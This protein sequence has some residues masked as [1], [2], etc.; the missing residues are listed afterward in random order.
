M[1]VQEAIKILSKDTSFEAVEELKYYAGFNQDKV[2][3]QIQEAMTMGAKALEKQI[4]LERIVERLEE[5]KQS[6]IVNAKFYQN[7]DD[8]KMH[9]VY[10]GKINAFKDAIEIVK[11][12]GGVDD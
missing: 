3:K 5:Q 10:V 8:E 11:E 7:K 12:E 1:T 6:D 4:L 9:A 2:I